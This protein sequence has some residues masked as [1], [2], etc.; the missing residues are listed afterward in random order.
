M[1]RMLISEAIELINK[2][3]ELIY[4]WKIGAP[5]V[6]FGG[7]HHIDGRAYQGLISRGY[8]PTIIGYEGE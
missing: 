5:K 7:E 3:G 8:K 4:Y 2:G 1:K 6:R